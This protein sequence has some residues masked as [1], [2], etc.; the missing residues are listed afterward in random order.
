MEISCRAWLNRGEPEALESREILRGRLDAWMDRFVVNAYY[1]ITPGEISV[2][3][4]DRDRIDHHLQESFAGWCQQRGRSFDAFFDEQLEAYG[5]AM[6]KRDY[7]S[8]LMIGLRAQMESH[9]VGQEHWSARIN[10]FLHS[11]AP[12]N[13]NFGK[14]VAGMLA[15]LAWRAARNQLAPPTQG[16]R[17]DLRAISTYLPYVD[18]MF[19]DNE[20]AR[21]L[22]EPPLRGRVPYE[23][24]IFSL[25]SRD[26]LLDWLDGI[27]DTSPPDHVKLVE[28]V[29]GPSWLKPRRVHEKAPC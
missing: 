25:A 28:R 6:A 12:T 4:A 17:A 27:E 20:C 9:G 16:L 24:R 3:R 11:E 18:A 7:L 5:P 21:L 19:V 23:T 29:Y 2:L 14:I 1:P 8:D 26:E 13:T 15:A 22:R 10:A